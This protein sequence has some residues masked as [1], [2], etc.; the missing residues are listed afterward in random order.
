MNT[1]GLETLGRQ[2]LALSRRSFLSGAGL[3]LGSMALASLER[4]AGLRVPHVPRAKRVIF[5]F[6]AGGPSQLDL[7]DHKPALVAMNG[8]PMPESLT[9]GN[10]VAQLQGRRLIAAGSRYAFK[11]HGQSGT[12]L[13]ELLPH[14]AT[15]VDKLCIVQSMW[16]PSINH[17]P[18]M[19]MMQTGHELPGR[20]AMGAWLS[21]G[22]GALNRDLP[23]FVVMISGAISG[24]QPLYARLWGA[25]FLPGR[26]QGVT[27]RTGRDPVLFLHDPPGVDPATRRTM[28]DTVRELNELEL[29]AVGDREVRTRIEAYELAFRMQTSVPDLVDLSNE[30]RHVLDLYGVEPGES[31]FAMNC[32]RARRLI[33]RDVRFV[34]L[35]DR[36]WDHHQ[37]LEPS[38]EGKCRQTDRAIA[39]LLVDLDRR[40]LLEDTL[41]I[42]GGEFGRSPMLQ[43]D[44]APRA[45]GRDHHG[46]AFTMWMAGAGVRAGTVHGSTDDLGYDIVKNKVDVHDLHATA[47]H[48]LGLDHEKLTVPHQGRDMRLTDVAGKVVRE[49]LA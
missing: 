27:L 10:R 7:F 28:L 14:T 33:E 48:L 4:A 13:S 19:T 24:A 18:G 23:A 49:L 26:H 15:V 2:Q 41:V 25:G 38:L 44:T 6:M 39:A 21:Y 29:G 37:I 8:Q 42:W 34:Q 35:C 22:L 3:S 12:W 43:G 36:G 20:P 32:L 5:L 46:R 30:P 45:F 16:T 1:V 40:G 47:L 11:R 9:R 17:D 31:S